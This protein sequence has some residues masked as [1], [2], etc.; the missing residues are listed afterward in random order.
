MAREGSEQG[1][2]K[3]YING[4]MWW[5]RSQSNERLE[6]EGVGGMRKNNSKSANGYSIESG[7]TLV[8]WW[9]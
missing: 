4:N 1:K 2:G 3:D 6:G 9:V 8:K 7:R 5:V